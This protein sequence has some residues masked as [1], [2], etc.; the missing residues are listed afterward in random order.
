M[1][2]KRSPISRLLP[3]LALLAASA[4]GGR[5]ELLP[6]A[7]DLQA[8]SETKP[9]P[10]DDIATSQLAA[11]QYSADVEAW[12]DRISAAGARLCRWTERVYKVRI[13]CPKEPAQ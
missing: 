1:S 10:T 13:G 12:G 3:L 7:A 6:P 4:C 11:D 9:A 5:G 8:V 2:S